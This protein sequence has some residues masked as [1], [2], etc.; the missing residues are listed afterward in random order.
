M[1]KDRCLTKD[2]CDTRN[3]IGLS[4]IEALNGRATEQISIAVRRWR[5]QQD[6]T[7]FSLSCDSAL[8]ISLALRGVS[9]W[10]VGDSRRFLFE[11]VWDG[12]KIYLVQMDV[13][14]TIGGADPKALLPSSIESTTP[15]PLKVFREAS[16][17]HKRKFR[18]IENAA[19]YEELG[20]TM[21]PFYVLYD[22]KEIRSLLHEG[23][24]SDE[25]RADLSQLTN[26]PLV[27]RTDGTDL[28]RDKREMLPRSEE[29]RTSDAA[30]DW[31]VGKFRSTIQ[32]LGL[33]DS[34]I[35]LIGHHFIPSVASAWAGAEPG[36]RWVRIEA[37]WGIPESLYWHSHDT[38]EVSVETAGLDAPK[39]ESVV[40]PLRSRERFKG[41]F[42]APDADGAWSHHET[43]VPHDWAPSI[44]SKEWLSEIAHTTRRICE[45]LGKPVEVMWF[46]ATHPNASS[47]RVLP[48]Y[49]SIPTNID[50]PISAPRKKI[51]TS[52]EHVLRDQRDWAILQ[53]AAR[54]GTRIERVI[55]EP[56]DPELVRNLYFAEELGKLAQ[57]HD[58]VVVLAGG[59][60]SH[61]YHALRRAGASVECIDLFGATEEKAEFNKLVRDNVP[62]QIADRGEHFEIVKLEGQA[63]VDA[64]RRKLVEEAL[65]ALDANAGT[66]LIGELADVEEILRAIAKAVGASLQELEEERLRKLKKRGGFEKGYLLLRTSSPHSIPQQVPPDQLI[67]LAPSSTVRTISDPST[68]PTKA[69]YKRPDHRNLADSTEE[70]LVVETE[71]N[72]LGTLEESID[73]EIPPNVDAQRYVS[74]IELSRRGGELRAV[75]RLRSRKRKGE[76]EGQTAFNFEAS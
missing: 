64:M 65:E 73:F 13:A 61:A 55:V 54:A 52:Q 7:E 30:I 70:L 32:Q 66:D 40:Y 46:V 2:E 49:H 21:P 16:A 9:R 24:L 76:A 26:R 60:L 62:A 43:K 50:L 35:A 1:H 18:K 12:T 68:V 69:L 39:D 15:A 6:S 74:S 34:D 72:R 45:H 57:Q 36:K 59:I 17:E 63:L 23:L 4:K 53:E 25:L 5:E 3:G 47:H 48:W 38:F 27:L 29:L 8:K 67:S 51:R 22:R 75:V 11:W 33:A 44:E 42:L 37:L 28:P 14:L 10:A 20:Y 19:L 41:T 71:L 56:R 58:I 31:L